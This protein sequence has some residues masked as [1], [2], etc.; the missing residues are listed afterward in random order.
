MKQSVLSVVSGLL[1]MR[2]SIRQ[3]PGRND[4]LLEMAFI[5]KI[6]LLRL[7][8]VGSFFVKA[9][10][11][12]LPSLKLRQVNLRMTMKYAGGNNDNCHGY[13]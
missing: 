4:H 13:I 10:E 6:L 7:F 2:K 8:K 3:L 5:G 12:D 11:R 1:R 9:N